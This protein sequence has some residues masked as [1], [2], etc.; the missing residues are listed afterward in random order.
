MDESYF[1]ISTQL[2]LKVK[3]AQQI[4]YENMKTLS[5]TVICT[6]TGH[7]PKSLSAS[8]VLSVKGEW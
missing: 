2:V 4:D 6:D 1:I 3:G 7:P 5:F 8:F